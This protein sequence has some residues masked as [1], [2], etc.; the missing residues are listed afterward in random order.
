MTMKSEVQ[1][2]VPRTEEPA[3]PVRTTFLGFWPKTTDAESPFE[4]LTMTY[5]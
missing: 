2:G 1:L 4:D 5:C 3:I